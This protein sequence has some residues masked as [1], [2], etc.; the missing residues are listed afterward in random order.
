MFIP[1]FGFSASHGVAKKTNPVVS[2]EAICSFDRRCYC[3][4][5]RPFSRKAHGSVIQIPD[6]GEL[7]G[8][9]NVP[10]GHG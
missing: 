5:T 4:K 1:G 10:A 8:Q 7:H 9:K 3:A 2:I 6:S